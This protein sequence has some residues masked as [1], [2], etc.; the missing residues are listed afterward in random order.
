MQ[1]AG[2]ALPVFT[3]S[4]AEITPEL[5][6]RF[7][8]EVDRGEATERTYRNNLLSF[9]AFLRFRAIR[10]PEREDLKGFREWLSREHK[11]ISYNPK[12]PQGWSYRRDGRGDI[13]RTIC[14]PSTV[15]QYLRTVGQFFKWMQ[16]EGIY[17]DIAASIRKPRLD[18][19][20]HSR[21]ALSPEEAAEVERALTIRAED[22]KG[23]RQ[24]ALFLLA[25]NAGLRTVELSRANIGDLE[26]RGRTVYLRI[27]GKGHTSADKRKP[28][29]IEVAEIIRDYLNTR[30][31]KPG[32]R[33]P[34]FAA[35]GNR[36]GGGRLSPGTISRLLKDAL[37]AGGYDSPRLTAHSLRH[38]AGAEVMTLTGNNIFL[39][40]SY[41]RH[42]NPKTTEIYL[43]TNT[44]RAETEIAEQLYSLLH[45]GKNA[46]Q[47]RTGRDKTDN[48]PDPEN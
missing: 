46:P 28:L 31:G 43:H 2:N 23:K 27:W 47:E 15:S 40:Q 13:I 20:E 25:I 34:L 5:L 14:N 48:S 36:N 45:T 38:T 26:Q 44:E 12:T 37:R 35:V 9:L 32:P 8:A 10:A 39:A 29:A 3:G 7:L 17:P 16:A 42:E 6:E 41:M 1:R 30:P 18:L 4:R 33:S 11:A 19:G 22:E 24:L 21:D